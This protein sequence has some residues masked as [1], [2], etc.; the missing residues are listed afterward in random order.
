[1][2]STFNISLTAK[3]AHHIGADFGVRAGYLGSAGAAMRD[4][5]QP[6]TAIVEAFRNLDA[7]AARGAG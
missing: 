7:L 5:A 2:T 4:A 3:T 1:M 6:R